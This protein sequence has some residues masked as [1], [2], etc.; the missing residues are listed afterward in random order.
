[1]LGL[2]AT[3]RCDAPSTV[4]A[5]L[6]KMVGSVA[7]VSCAPLLTVTLPGM[8]RLGEVAAVSCAASSGSIADFAAMVGLPATVR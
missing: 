7:A 6:A 1:M 3:T 4:T 5:D 8:A 2:V